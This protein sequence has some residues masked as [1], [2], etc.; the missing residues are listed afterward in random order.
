MKKLLL[1]LLFSITIS[2]GAMAQTAEVLAR[3]N[4]STSPRAPKGDAGSMRLIYYLSASEI[5]AAGIPINSSLSSIG[6]VYSAAP[7]IATTGN[8]RILL[9]NTTDTYLNK[10]T[11]WS[12][13]TTGMTVVKNETATIGTTSPIKYDFQNS[14]VWTG[15]GLYVAMEFVNAGT[16]I[17]TA[18]A[19]TIRTNSGTFSDPA[20]DATVTIRYSTSTT[21]T[22]PT[23][24]TTTNSASRPVTLFDY[25]APT[26]NITDL[27]VDMIYVLDKK[28]SGTN[29]AESIKAVVRNVNNIA[30]ANKDVTLNVSGANNFT[31]V[32]QVTLNPGESTVVTFDSFTSGTIGTNTID[33]TVADD[34]VLN[35]KSTSQTVNDGIYA[36]PQ[37]VNTGS[38]GVGSSDGGILLVKYGI[39]GS[40][41]IKAVN[42]TLGTSSTL[43]VGTVKVYA[44]VM[45]PA[46]VTLGRSDDYTVLSTDKGTK[47]TFL[48]QTPVS[49]TNQEFLVG[50]AYYNVTVNTFPVSYYAESPIRTNVLYRR[51]GGLTDDIAVTAS[52]AG[53]PA[54]EAVLE[55][56]STLPVNIKTFNAKLNNGKVN[57]SWTVGTE[58]NVNRYE[59]ERSANGKDFVK[60]ATVTALGNASYSV[61]DANPLIGMNY[62]RLQGVDNDGTLSPFNELRSVKLTALENLNAVVYPNPLVGNAINISLSNYA[63]GDYQY[64]LVD[65]L[66]KVVQ[67]G[68]IKN[69]GSET[70]AIA[71]SNSLNK[72]IYLLHLIAGEQVIQSK[73]VKR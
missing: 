56:S 45:T 62:Y 72:G 14:F 22:L 23:S 12:T 18:S 8:T 34:N 33:V 7:T 25:T 41:N 50:L 16:S 30:V 1:L 5:I 57:L 3:T 59:V 48:L 20:G 53:L 64:K 11:T 69:N 38:L 2:T 46:G 40:S 35:N 55:T 21:T 54:I 19:G 52:A 28:P 27:S 29:G 36:Y 70:S 47:K 39:S 15:G 31:N 71:V 4:T 10:S 67:Q 68:N 24:T 51:V 49:L 73:L 26:T 66:G 17:A 32:K 65:A 6:F 44:V 63:G 61:S 58:T 37:T 13:A 42:V 60:V 9:Q 43:D